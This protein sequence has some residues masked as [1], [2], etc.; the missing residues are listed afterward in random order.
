MSK[1]DDD[2]KRRILIWSQKGL[3]NPDISEK[4]KKEYNVAVTPEAIRKHL[5]KEDEVLKSQDLEDALD[6]LDEYV[7][8]MCRDHWTIIQMK[9][10][11]K[12]N[13]ALRRYIINLEGKSNIQ[14]KFKAIDWLY[15]E[16]IGLGINFFERRVWSFE[17]A[18]KT[19]FNWIKR[20]KSMKLENDV[21]NN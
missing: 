19:W 13:A 17:T 5:L 2:A 16:L 9:E 8:W 20:M 14:E 3:S 21:D 15:G 4:L 18:R 10:F 7:H 12:L 6:R 11:K 1:L